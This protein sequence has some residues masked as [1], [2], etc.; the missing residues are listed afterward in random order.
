[1]KCSGRYDILLCDFSCSVAVVERGPLVGRQQEWNI[2]RKELK[3]LVRHDAC[4]VS[5]I[6]FCHMKIP[7]CGGTCPATGLKQPTYAMIHSCAEQG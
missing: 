2:S 6:E 7:L 5:S 3:E 4:T 1:M